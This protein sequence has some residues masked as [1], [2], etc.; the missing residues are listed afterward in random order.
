MSILCFHCVFFACMSMFNFLPPNKECC[1][2]L[3]LYKSSAFLKSGFPLWDKIVH[4]WK[5]ISM[6][7]KYAKFLHPQTLLVKWVYYYTCLRNTKTPGWNV[8]CIV[9]YLS[10]VLTQIT[11][12]LNG[13]WSLQVKYHSTTGVQVC[14]PVTWNPSVCSSTTAYIIQRC[15]RKIKIRQSTH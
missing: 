7:F 2:W 12:L 11:Y 4:F 1:F 8:Y 3:W 13:R 5:F 14:Q 10:S 15:A 6:L 9:I